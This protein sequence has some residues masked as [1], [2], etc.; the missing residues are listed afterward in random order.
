MAGENG[1]RPLI[2]VPNL[3]DSLRRA[4]SENAD[5]SD[6]IAELRETE[7]A[8]LEILREALDPVFNQIPESAAD[9]FDHGLLPG[10]KPRLYIDILAFIELARDQRTYRFVRDTRWGQR[11]IVETAEVQA[12]VD[13]VANYVA[14]RLVEREKALRSD[15]FASPASHPPAR[16]KAKIKS[17]ALKREPSFDSARDEPQQIASEA[18]LRP[19][20]IGLLCL[21]GGLSLGVGSL[22]ALGLL[23]I[24][25][26]G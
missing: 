11:P 6:A 20:L 14:A 24:T 10:E 4:R 5:R 9:L 1:I 21:V 2:E 19:M 23:R 12:V 22:L 26:I 3:Q 15:E 16:P 7:I 25:W 18:W 8:R 17:Q 13:A